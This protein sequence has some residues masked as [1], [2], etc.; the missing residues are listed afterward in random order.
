[1]T[2]PAATPSDGSGYLR[3]P[4]LVGDLVVFVC[5]D[6]LWSVPAAGG[7]AR[8]LTAGGAGPCSGPRLSPDGRLVAFTAAPEGTPEVCVISVGGGPVRR[9]TSQ[10]GDCLVLGWHPRTGDV[11]YAATAGLPTGFGRR[12]FAVGPG[13]GPPRL[14]EAGPAASVAYGP[15]GGVVIGRSLADPAR[16]KRYRGGAAGELWVDADGSG[17]FRRLELPPGNPAFPC[18]VGDR[19]YFVSDHDGTGNVHSCRPDG[20]GLTR[21]T[22]H[23]DYYVRG[24]TGDGER[25]VYHQGARLR[26]LD[27]ADPDGRD[28]PVP[29][30]VTPS[31]AQHQRRIVSAAGDLDHARLSPDASRLVV[32]SRGKVF[33]LAPFDGPVRRHGTPDGVRY[34]LP[35]WLADGTRLVA[36][37]GDDAPGE[38]LVLLPAEGGAELDSLPL[39]DIGYV[40]D[41]AAAPVGGQV[42]FATN[43]QQLW[44]VDTDAAHPEPR[45]LDSSPYDRIED[46]AWSPDGRWL[47]YT[48]PGTR[49]TT[50]VKVAEP[51]TGRTAHLTS[52]VLR[53]FAPAFDPL[54]RYLYFLG[55][56][57]LLPEY[58][59]VQFDVGFPL[60]TR[61]YAVLL[62]AGTPPP[63]T[64]APAPE[65][66]GEQ[67]VEV[68]IDL[69][70]VD[71]RVVALPL[72]HGRY[73]AVRGLPE[74]V[75]VLGVPL[76]GPAADG[77]EDRRRTR[78]GTVTVV[79][80]ATG[81]TTEDYLSPVDETDTDPSG[82]FLLYRHEHRIRVVPAGVPRTDVEDYD[83]IVS[84][85]GR[86]T[87]WIDLARVTVPFRPAAEWRQ[88][89]REAWRLQKEGFWHSGMSGVDWEAVHDRYLPLLARVATRS[90]L[91]DLLWELQGELATSHAYERGGDHGRPPGP[92]G[93][94]GR[95]GVDWEPSTGPG[96]GWRIARVVRGEPWNP[97]ATS[98]CGLPGVDIRAGDEVVAVDGHPVGP[99][100]P[101]EPLA[102]LAGCEVELTV[103]R[104]GAAPRRV[105]V[106]AARDEGRARY[107]EWVEANR[108]WVDDASG[109]RLAYLHIPDMFHTGYADFVRQFLTGLDHDGLIVDVR[110]NGGGSASPMILDRLARRRAGVEH[111]RWSGEVPYPLEAPHGPMVALVNEQTGSDGE[112]FGHM[113]RAR[114][115]GSLIGTRTWGGTIAT[116]PR[117]RLVDGTLTTQPEFC[118]HLTGV[119]TGLE[120]RGV[121][122]DITVELPPAG[123]DLPHPD[124]QLSTAVTHLLGSLPPL[125]APV[126]APAPHADGRP[127]LVP[128]ARRPQETP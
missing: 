106:R 61:P 90:E 100:G 65:A 17:S 34:R 96:G 30:T 4:T 79:E 26:L 89:Y 105:T 109:G 50:A 88:M 104:P 7:T 16:R 10:A 1:M 62:T 113:F 78:E 35:Q 72:P 53:D 121:E 74:S 18:W 68:R 110:H 122:P 63:F 119:G 24:L 47:A 91:S 94:P 52:P 80:L 127:S 33:T 69:D 3:Q 12:L 95:L 20:S 98:P 11:V 120:N 101:G 23:T 64:G 22:H 57:D 39:G 59:Q 108:R 6:D 38:R 29:V 51:A 54:G 31:G 77:P 71:G 46:L 118:Y 8:R 93:G 15:D 14:L 97:E 28:R 73:A 107:V 40:T 126:L 25:L 125:T 84:P 86:E 83:N 117:H 41:L 36:A 70:G 99:L 37:A 112:I 60:G 111:S 55:Q 67:P 43:R 85:P 92:G 13:G 27:P 45:L 2:A 56:R 114:G 103:L 75:L 123:P 58:D 124:P 81:E 44:S 5:E 32:A 87:G 42:A 115:L 116:W 82:A 19:I 49:R 102:G 76:A 48:F 9:L 21:H 128:S 66:D